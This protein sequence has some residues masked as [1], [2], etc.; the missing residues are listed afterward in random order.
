[1]YL[2]PCLPSCEYS[3]ISPPEYGYW[4]SQ[5]SEQFYDHQD[6]LCVSFITMYTFPWGMA[7][8]FYSPFHSAKLPGDS[9]NLCV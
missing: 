3:T 8:T 5:D 7:N 6:P 2:L 9:F 4:Y 1:M